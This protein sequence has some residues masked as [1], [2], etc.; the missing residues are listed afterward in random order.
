MPVCHSLPQL[1][2]RWGKHGADTIWSTCGTKVLLGSIS[3][4]DTLE[5][6]SK[7]CGTVKLGDDREPTVPPELLRMLPD[8]RALVIRMNLSPAIV[9]VRPAWR[10]LPYRFGR[11]P[12][13]VPHLLTPVFH[14][15]PGVPVPAQS[16]G[17][18]GQPGPLVGM[19]LNQP[20]TLP[21]DS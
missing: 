1:E 20:P 19:G 16:N 18:G 11:H 10:R 13:P 7:L 17:H 6:A 2:A 15:A 4:P 12:L 8:W 5:H 9:K 3:D 14:P 21:R